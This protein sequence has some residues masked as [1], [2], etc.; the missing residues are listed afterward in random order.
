MTQ[1]VSNQ[2]AL[3]AEGAEDNAASIDY[4]E[5]LLPLARHWRS[6]VC[7]FILSGVLGTWYA[8]TLTPIFTAKSLFIPP[9][10]QS[11]GASALASLGALAGMAGLGGAA[12]NTA[13]EYVAML[14]SVTVRDRMIDKFGLMAA[15]KSEFRDKARDILG[16]RSLFTIGKKDGLITVAVDDEDPKRAAAMAN[17]YIDELRR[18]TS[19][20]AISEAQRRRMFFEEKLKETKDRLTNAQIA[21]QGS[22][23]TEGALKA[24]PRAAAEGY[25]RLQAELTASV[26]ALQTM[27]E[28]L[29]DGSV[30]VQRQIAK[31]NALREQVQ[32]LEKSN[33]AS[34]NGQ[35]DFVGKYREFKY[36]EALFE[37][38][39][40]QYELARVDESREG[41]LIQVVDP[42]EPPE[43]KSRPARLQFG[44]GTAFV[45]TFLYALFLVLRGRIRASL[46]DP[47][48]AQRW[49]MVRSALRRRG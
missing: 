47:Q 19:T 40:K 48:R 4:V 11:S 13:D 45:L 44:V 38:M 15:Y 35:T 16:K 7:V 31:V 36:Q 9:Q 32:A 39:A 33:G 23:F 43:H 17:Q 18:L 25:A 29:A 3:H 8:F 5:L 12:K 28:T 41:A 1:A 34:G 10:Q 37:M 49:A 21:L 20:L 6:L 22:G 42:A 2:S 46:A 26:V 14:Q 30:E 24:E 27:R